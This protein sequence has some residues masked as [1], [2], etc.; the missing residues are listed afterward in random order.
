MTKTRPP[1]RFLHLYLIIW[2]NHSFLTCYSALL[3]P[4]CIQKT[5]GGAHIIAFQNTQLLEWRSSCCPP[6]APCPHLTGSHLHEA[7]DG[8]DSPVSLIEGIHPGVH[9]AIFCLGVLWTVWQETGNIFHCPVG[10]WQM[11]VP[12]GFAFQQCLQVFCFQRR[13]SCEK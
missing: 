13:N 7:G 1:V 6:P 4:G 12:K 5:D 8:L 9:R 3:I 2:I 10:S 11:Q